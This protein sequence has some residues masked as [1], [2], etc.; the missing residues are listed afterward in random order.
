MGCILR[1]FVL[2]VVGG[3]A[4]DE[5][6]IDFNNFQSVVTESKQPWIIEFYSE[7]CG[8][9]KAFAPTW[10]GFREKV[11]ACLLLLF[12][13]REIWEVLRSL[14]RPPV[15][16]LPLQLENIQD[17]RVGR[18]CVDK[19]PGSKL[20]GGLGLLDAGIPQIAYFAN[21]WGGNPKEFSTLE[22]TTVPE[23]VD[24]LSAV[25]LREQAELERA[26]HLDKLARS[27]EL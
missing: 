19:P 24:S 6:A 2:L 23:L 9:C 25:F 4:A 17:L 18:V 15:P 14:L 7:L 21:H 11:R 27:G 1:T 26:E 20:A 13:V 12:S 3:L 16:L 8:S 10:D 5:V 22:G